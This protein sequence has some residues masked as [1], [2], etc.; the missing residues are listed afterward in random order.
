MAEQVSDL[1]LPEENPYVNLT[2]GYGI[3]MV[4]MLEE[5]DC[6]IMELHCTK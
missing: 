6:V 4:I 1:D 3:S 5:I 2:E